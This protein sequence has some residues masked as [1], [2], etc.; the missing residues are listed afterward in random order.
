MTSSREERVQ[1]AQ[2]L[3]IEDRIS[4]AVAMLESVVAEFPED[5]FALRTLGY[6]YHEQ[7]RLVDS[8]RLLE[9]AMD[10]EPMVSQV[11]NALAFRTQIARRLINGQPPNEPIEQS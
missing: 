9:R 6:L 2:S 3:I 7:G 4:E 5:E 8:V 1:T 11:L 10:V